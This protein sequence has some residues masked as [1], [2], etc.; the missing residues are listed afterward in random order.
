MFA[1][2]R[3]LETYSLWGPQG[4]LEQ[5]LVLRHNS[6]MW[7]KISL[8]GKYPSCAV[9]L[10]SFSFQDCRSK[11]G[12]PVDLHRDGWPIFDLGQDLATLYHDQNCVFRFCVSNGRIPGIHL[13]RGNNF[14]GIRSDYNFTWLTCVSRNH[15]HSER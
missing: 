12:L 1:R 14:L 4:E 15:D 7:R 13:S 2:L 10:S 5:P 11:K 8:L 9:S 3:I 6:W